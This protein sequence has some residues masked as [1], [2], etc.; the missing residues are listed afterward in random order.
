MPSLS[1]RNFLSASAVGAVGVGLIVL[2]QNV[3]RGEVSPNEKLNLAILGVGGRG[4]ANLNGCM[5]ENIYALCDTNRN[6]LAKT[7]EEFPDAIRTTDWRTLVDNENIDAFIVS[8]AEHHHALASVAAMRAGKS[9]YTEKPLARTVEEARLMQNE[10]K[11]QR[12]K[13][14]TQMGTQIHAGDNYR[15]VVELIQRGA[16]GKVKEAHVWCSR[17]I[18]PIGA[19]VLD[20]QPVPPE[21]AW[22]EWIGP[23]PMRAF[24]VNYL[25]GSCL[26]WHRR[27]DF[28]TGVLGDMGS[29]LIDLPYWALELDIPIEAACEGPNPDPVATP[30]WMVATWKH[31]A[32]KTSSEFTSG[33][34]KLVW[35]HG[36]EGMKRR[37]DLLQPLVGNDTTIN[38]W[39]IG[40]AFIG[41]KGTLV[42]DY[43]KNVLSP[44]ADFANYERPE[45]FIP[46]S[47]GHYKEFILAAKGGPESLCNF[48]Y[49]GRLIENNLLGNAAHRAGNKTLTWDASKFSFTNAPEMDKFLRSDYEYRTGWVF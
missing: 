17:T 43:G 19:A 48:D 14:A 10:Y 36:P 32:R 46:A 13:I 38:Q 11:K 12:G 6:T 37:S 3:V 33:D 2:P 22:E 47:A 35:Y 16:I 34:I 21:Y 23:A 18:A 44:S 28:G 29:H 20:E 40:V 42:A 49:S 7:G 27:W 15:R 5:S 9:V 1:R 26:N 45:P 31:A 25:N 39:G 41:E 4:R 24:N 30:P 8:T